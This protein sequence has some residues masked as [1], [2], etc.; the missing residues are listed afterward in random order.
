AAPPGTGR[1][2]RIPASRGAGGN[3]GLRVSPV[4]PRRGRP[5]GQCRSG[6]GDPPGDGRVRAGGT[7]AV[8]IRAG[9]TPGAPGTAAPTAPVVPVPAGRTRR[10]PG[11]PRRLG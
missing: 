2:T 5:G 4:R 7:G 1:R 3:R 6:R 9:P 8:A 10:A 11:Q